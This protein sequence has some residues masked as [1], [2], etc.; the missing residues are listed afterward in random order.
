MGLKTLLTTAAFVGAAFATTAQATTVVTSGTATVEFTADL[1]A[2]GL[3]IT[4]RQWSENAAGNTERTF[5]IRPAEGLEYDW[6]AGSGAIRTSTASATSQSVVDDDGNAYLR[7][8]SGTA[9]IVA[10]DDDGNEI[11]TFAT[12]FVL[13]QNG[14]NADLFSDELRDIN[15]IATADPLVFEDFENPGNFYT[16]TADEVALMSEEDNLRLCCT[17][18]LNDLAI[19]TAAMAV[20]GLLDDVAERDINFDGVIDENDEFFLFDLVATAEDGVFDMALTDTF[21]E[22]LNFAFSP[23]GFA[24]A[25]DLIEDWSNEAGFLDFAGGDVIGNLSYSYEVAAVPVPASM[26][27]LIG[28]LGVMGY[29]GRRRKQRKAA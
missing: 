21:A 16:F 12:V 8:A 20:D 3:A 1:D 10:T 22:F 17:H 13:P 25:T 6:V 11:E 4:T 19:D 23:L 14:D 18:S 29:V 27:L 7:F 15:Y 2:L 9:A 28:G 24:D 5:T 26:P